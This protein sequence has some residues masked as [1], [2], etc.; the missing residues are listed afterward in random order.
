MEYGKE[1]SPPVTPPSLFGRVV[2][3][4]RPILQFGLAAALLGGLLWRV[5][6]GQVRD[7]LRDATLWWLPIAFAANLG[8]DWFRAIRWQQFFAPMKHLPLPFLFATAVL[9][10]AC[11]IVLPLR[12]GEVV[13]VQVLRRRTGLAAAKIVATLLS[14][15]LMDI[16]AFSSF[17]IVGIIMYEEARFMWPLAIVYGFVLLGGIYGARWLARRVREGRQPLFGQPEG[18]WRAWIAGEVRSF[19]EGLQAF[20]S[21]KILIIVALA[22]IAAWTCEAAMYY[23]CGQSLGLDVPP[24]VYLLVVVTATIVVSIPVTPAGL[25]VFE[26]AITGLLVAFGV[27]ESEAAAFSIF[28]HVMLALPYIV[29]GPI[30]AVALRLNLSDVFFLRISPDDGAT[31][32]E[33]R[34][35]STT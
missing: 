33:A 8:S 3:Y 14:E 10:V 13:R 26:L 18:R 27:N 9:G 15:K 32:T 11:N 22:S 31:P 6:L 16:F 17:I 4:L 35:L 25:G 30:A 28:A 7:D 19:G 24:F 23:A 21:A 34:E 2:P 5:D 29:C 20:R 1:L 12:A